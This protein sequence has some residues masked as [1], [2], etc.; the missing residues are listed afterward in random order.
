MSE[1]PAGR[2][3]LLRHGETEWSR[4]GLHTGVTDVPLTA[5]GEEQAGAAG[6][7][8]EVLRGADAP[9]PAVWCS[10]RIRARDTAR[11]AGLDAEHVRDELAEWDYGDYEGRSTP[12]IRTEVPG[13]TVWTHA[14]PQGETHE[15]IARRIDAVLADAESALADRDLVLVGHSHA[16][17]VLVARYLGLSPAAGVG[18]AFDPAAV[19]VL[20]RERGVP[21]IDLLNAPGT[22]A[23]R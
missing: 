19:T 12:D 10:P 6:R 14:M 23:D 16:S 22:P 5:H 2:L 15:Q 7:L 1:C 18:F 11:A 20:G 21:R 4:A 8:L 9:P 17:R 3:Y 13:W